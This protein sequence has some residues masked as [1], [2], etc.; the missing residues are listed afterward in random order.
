MFPL[1]DVSSLPCPWKMDGFLK[2]RKS[3]KFIQGWPGTKKGPWRYFM[4][5]PPNCGPVFMKIKE[6]TT[7]DTEDDWPAGKSPVCQII[8][9]GLNSAHSSLFEVV[10]PARLITWTINGKSK[11]ES[12]AIGQTSTQFTFWLF[13]W[14]C[15]IRKLLFLIGIW[16]LWASYSLPFLRAIVLPDYFSNPH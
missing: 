14:G 1:L 13:L 12:R 15:T 11:K 7:S 4:W 16:F 5:V 2:A 8:S 3:I 6:K 10:R 9:P